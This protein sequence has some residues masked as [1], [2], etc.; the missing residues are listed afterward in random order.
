VAA[1]A[2]SNEAPTQHQNSAIVAVRSPD[3]ALGA[4][5]RVL[6]HWSGGRDGGAVHDGGPIVGF[7]GGGGGGDDGGGNGSVTAAAWHAA[8]GAERSSGA[9][10]SGA[11]SR[12]AGGGAGRR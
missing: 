9:V 12:Q 10:G 4:L 2:K 7:G 6:V 5:V 1:P 3:V 11:L 8:V